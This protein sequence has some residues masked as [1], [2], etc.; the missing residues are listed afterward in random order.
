MERPSRGSAVPQFGGLKGTIVLRW[1]TGKKKTG[2]VTNSKVIC[3]RGG[4]GIKEFSSRATSLAGF[5]LDVSL[6]TGHLLVGVTG[7]KTL[8]LCDIRDLDLGDR[9]S[10][11]HVSD[12]LAV[13]Q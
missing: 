4:K 7:R 10:G 5:K 12:R 1:P 8:P 13:M 9:V 11:E 6:I 3:L 2:I